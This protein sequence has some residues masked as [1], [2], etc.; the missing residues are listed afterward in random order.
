M[1]DRTPPHPSQ[2]ELGDCSLEHPLRDWVSIELFPLSHTGLMDR[3]MD[4][5]EDRSAS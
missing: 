3:L 2:H 5:I 1:T 4:R